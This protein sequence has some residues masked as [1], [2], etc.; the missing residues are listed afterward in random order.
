ALL[1]LI[2]CANLANLLLTRATARTRELAMRMALGSGTAR[3]VRQVLT[4]SLVLALPGG[5][6]GVLF[7]F[8][9]ITTLN[10]WKPLVLQSYPPLTLDLTTLGFSAGLTFLTALIFGM[11][12][13]WTSG[14]IRIQEALK[15]AGPVNAGSRTATRIRHILVVTQLG[16]AL[17]LLISAGLL[18]RSFVKLATTDLG[19]SA[20][21]VLTLRL[22][23]T[24]SRYAEPEKQIQF[25]IDVLE[26]VKRLPQVKAAAFSSDLP[27]SG[28]DRFYSGAQFEIAG[29][30]LPMAQRPQ[31][32][33]TVVSREFFRTL[34][35]PLR[36]GR[37]FDFEDTEHSRDNIIVNEAFAKK[38]FPAENALYQRIVIGP[39]N[40]VSWRIVGI[41]GNIRGGQVGAE[42]L[43]LIYRCLCQGGGT[44]LSRSGLLVRTTGDPHN[45]VPGVVGQ[46][47]SVDRAEPVFDVVK[48][49][50]ERLAAALAPRRFY[51]LLIG[52][53]T[54]I[55]ILLSA[56]GVFGVMSYLVTQRNRE[57]GIRIAIGAQSTRVLSLVLEESMILTSIGIV[58]GVTGA[59]GVTR[60]LNSMLYGVTALDALTFVSM[61]ILLI[62]VSI[63]ASL[64]P[65]IRA[66]QIDP[67]IVLRED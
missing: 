46:I 28:D 63:F 57:I 10:G 64:I 60:Y 24:G 2:A 61:P 40:P 54:V 59:W 15:S 67:A 17:V 42:P 32:G 55:A 38:V 43:P 7:A 58:I 9:A 14:R 26:R 44:E 30:P 1:L 23:L 13:A 5:A 18:S 4:E 51:L 37:L 3:I 53:F 20:D 21:N 22:N 33:I 8:L 65:A 39:N 50:D 25:Y 29:H 6:M 31:A 56:V 11:A 35:I 27:L 62:L 34:E 52:T 41:V 36:A 12:P 47:L 48:T 66:V 19:F 16:V 45:A 49:M